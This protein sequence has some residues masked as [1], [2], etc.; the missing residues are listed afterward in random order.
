MTT[1]VTRHEKRPVIAHTPPILAVPIIPFWVAVTVLVNVIAAQLEVVGE[2]HAAPMAPEDAPSMQAM[3]RMGANFKEF[4]SN[5]TVMIVVEGQQALGPDAHRYY[6]EIIRKLRQD[7][8]HIQHIQDFWADTL[9]AAG[10]PSSGGKAP[11]VVVKLAGGEGPT[12]GKA[13]REGVRNG[14]P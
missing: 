9:T 2:A 8:K 13:G 4:D 6:D 11:S 5:S 7:P 3:K 1:T 14:P 12:L 10:T